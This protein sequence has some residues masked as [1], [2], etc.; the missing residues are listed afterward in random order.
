M[1]CSHC[2]KLSQPNE[3]YCSECGS[4]LAIAPSGPAQIVEPAPAPTP[5]A[6]AK[7]K[8]RLIVLFGAIGL[9]LTLV[10]GFLIYSLPLRSD[11]RLTGARSSIDGIMRDLE[12]SVR[13]NQS[14]RELRYALNPEDPHDPAAYRLLA[15]TGGALAREAKLPELTLYDQ[16]NRSWRQP[17]P[18][19]RSAYGASRGNHRLYLMVDT[20][21]GRSQPKEFI[22]NYASAH[23]AAPDPAFIRSGGEGFGTVTNELLVSV[24]PDVARSVVEQLA[25]SCGAEIVGEI[26]DI[27]KYQFR[28]TQSEAAVD[29]IRG[30]L[31]ADAHVALVQFNR[32]FTQR[33]LAVYPNDKRFDS[34]DV[35]QP[36]GNNWGLEA[37]R[38][39]LVWGD[40]AQLAPVRVGIVDGSIEY[41]HPD[42]QVTREHIFLFPTWAIQTID[43]LE[44]Y[45]A[46]S[47]R[48]RGRDY[49][50]LL[51]HGTHV[52]G[53]V[54][55]RGNN[56]EGICGVNWSPELM[57][58]HF[59]HMDI[60][61]GDGT[62]ELWNVSTS[63]ELDAS[64]TTL[65]SQGC[66]VLNYSV[67][68][69]N[70]SRPGSEEERDATIAFGD[71]CLRLEEAGYDFL[72]CKAAGNE[73]DDAS[74]Y[75]MNR[76]M[77]GTEAA[78]RHVV[79]VGSI[80]NEALPDSSISGV[81]PVRQA[82]RLSSFSN[83]GELVDVAAPGSEIFSTVPDG[84]YGNLSGTSMASPV[85]AGV[86]SLIYSAHPEYHA[87]HVKEILMTQTDCWTSDGQRA[88]PVVNAAL[89]TGFAL[90][91]E[92]PS[93]P[94]GRDIPGPGHYDGAPPEHGPGPAPPPTPTPTP[95]PDPVAPTE[96]TEP[97]EST[98]PTESSEPVPS[99]SEVTEP[100]ITAPEDAG[101]FSG[102]VID[103]RTR[104][105]LP[106]F[107][108][109]LQRDGEQIERF[110]QTS[111][112]GAFALQSRRAAGTTVELIVAAEGYR[113]TTLSEVEI[114][115]VGQVLVL[116]NI[117]LFSDTMSEDPGTISGRIIDAETGE[118][119]AE[120]QIQLR[121]GR[122]DPDGA[123]AVSLVSDAEG[124]YTRTLDA[125]PYTLVATAEG[126]VQGQ[127]NATVIAGET[128][129]DQDCTLT[130]PIAVDQLRIVLTWGEEPEDLDSI[131]FCDF[132]DGS[133]ALVYFANSE[134]MIDG[135]R[136]IALDVDDT[137][138]YGPETT[139]FYRMPDGRF[140]F[141]VLN[142]SSLYENDNQ[143]LS[144][145][146]AM[147]TVYAGD[148]PAKVFQTPPSQ[149]GAAWHVFSIEDGA[150]VAVDR[151]QSNEAMLERASD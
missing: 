112:D 38:A 109:T 28:F 54:G 33:E 23:V 102:Y 130:R 5:P 32:S 8:T 10:A 75:A 16:I 76:I 149:N 105:A 92:A 119:I 99:T 133:R 134:H 48:D 136:V 89:G 95:T 40:A 104:Q 6:A 126:Y 15:S 135:E 13:S 45:Y 143:Q 145:S 11:I 68:D 63:F 58:F 66:R 87:G 61:E 129:E 34:W 43:D 22:L 37:I 3:R 98:E 53:I 128:R 42:L 115:A 137:S 47:R 111:A 93:L 65:V 120:A 83:R 31:Q 56:D 49:Y 19:A 150:I 30:R 82:Y 124:R 123:I 73:D 12:V 97:S 140:E 60:K 110:E 4:S 71:L 88:I 132:A 59:W 51:E 52:S 50:E 81:S 113:P 9:V 108:L 44:L 94:P 14:I 21:F 2:G 62:I 55:A 139:T 46:K 106:A 26:P 147:V 36:E 114:P 127:A 57:F 91:G 103:A 118:G 72:I 35:A 151:I 70:P 138:S 86:A 74:H 39:P 116:G 100:P 96:P 20:L 85:V 29:E 25:F 84:G 121:L 101:R 17:G 117:E 148:L 67:G 64:I 146:G 125:G 144:Q 131:T 41:A 69:T 1:F 18:F 90:I 27:A 78:Q 77:T 7:K 80:A 107:Q 122:N 24:W 141:W 142:Y 79:I